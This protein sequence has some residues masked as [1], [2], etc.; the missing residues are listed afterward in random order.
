MQKTDVSKRNAL[1]IESVQSR[2]GRKV[3]CRIDDVANRDV[4]DS[5]ALQAYNHHAGCV[6]ECDSSSQ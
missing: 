1:E 3:V 4:Y 2:C 6:R 5:T